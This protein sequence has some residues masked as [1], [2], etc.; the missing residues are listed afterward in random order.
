MDGARDQTGSLA[1]AM[2]V[3]WADCRNRLASV[4]GRLRDRIAEKA[5]LAAALHRADQVRH[6]VLDETPAVA[7]EGRRRP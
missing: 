1:E 3:A 4:R 2:E 7:V 5:D 6:M